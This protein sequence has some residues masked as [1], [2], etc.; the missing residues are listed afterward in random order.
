MN[1]RVKEACSNAHGFV[2][3][4]DNDHLSALNGSDVKDDMLQLNENYR[5]E[6]N[7]LMNEIGA[8]VPLLILSLKANSLKNMTSD[9]RSGDAATKS[10]SCVDIIHVLELNKLKQNW[11]TRNCQIFQPR[12]KDI[13]LGFEWILNELDLKCIDQQMESSTD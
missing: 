10:L 7:V 2:Y 13:T 9:R 5:T 12:M 3:V 1:P 6:L 4:I 8:D 11:Q